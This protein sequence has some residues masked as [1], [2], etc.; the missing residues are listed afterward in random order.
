MVGVGLVSL[1][2]LLLSLSSRTRYSNCLHT[3]SLPLSPSPAKNIKIPT[4]PHKSR[5]EGADSLWGEDKISS[6]GQ[7]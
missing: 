7:S 3:L 6:S 1:R 4:N 5:S 2:I